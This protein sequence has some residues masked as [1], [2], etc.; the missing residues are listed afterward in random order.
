MIYQGSRRFPAASNAQSEAGS[1]T[2]RSSRASR[3]GLGLARLGRMRPRPSRDPGRLW[4]LD[5]RLARAFKF[6]RGLGFGT[7]LGS[8]H[9]GS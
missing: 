4:N 3:A 1:T 8:G 7:V 5:L 9:M 6:S 2:S